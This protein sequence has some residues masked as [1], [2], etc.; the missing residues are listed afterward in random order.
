MILSWHRVVNGFEIQRVDP[1]NGVLIFRCTHFD[2][3]TCFC[4]SYESRPGI[5][6]DYPAN[7]LDSPAPEFFQECGFRAVVKNAEA[8]THALQ[9]AGVTAETL[10]ELKKKLYLE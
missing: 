1:R 5:C 3:D 2:P 6:R 10:A 4:D 8:L 9:D 7:L